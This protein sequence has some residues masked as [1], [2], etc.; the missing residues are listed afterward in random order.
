VVV[1][2]GF[3]AGFEELGCFFGADGSDPEGW[4]EEDVGVDLV[5]YFL[6]E[7]EES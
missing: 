3:G 5:S 4:G 1:D 6:G 7:R 2:F